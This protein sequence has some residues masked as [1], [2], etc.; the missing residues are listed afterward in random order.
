[1]FNYPAVPA[2]Y[3]HSTIYPDFDFETY[4]E[5]G[6]IYNHAARKWEGKGLSEVGAAVYSEHPTAVARCMTYNLKEGKGRQA[7]IPGM[8][9]P[10]DLFDHI[11]NGGLIEAHNSMFEFLIWTNVC[12]SKYG[13][14]P[15]SLDQL[16]C[17]MSKCRAWSIPAS[18]AKAAKYTGVVDKIADG[19]RLIRKFCI[20]RKPT[21]TDDRLQLTLLDSPADGDKLIEY[22]LG[23]IE[24]ESALSAKVP[25]LQPQEL[26]MWKLDQKI[27]YRGV[28][29]DEEA[30][31][32]CVAVT[33]EYFER[34]TA[35]LVEITGGEVN[36]VAEVAKLREYVNARIVG[37]PIPDVQASTIKE[38][39]SREGLSS[40]V[41]RVLE[42]RKS[43]AS[44]SVKKVYAMNRMKSKDGRL[45]NLF[46]YQGADRTGRFAGSGP[47]PQN[48]PNSGPDVVSCSYCR[49]TAAFAT[50]VGKNSIGETCG[51]GGVYQKEEWGFEASEAF[52]NTLLHEPYQN[53]VYGWGE[54]IKLVTGSLRGLFVA[55]EGHDL[56]CSD[57]SAIEAVVLAALAGE[58]WR[59]EVFRTHGKIY[60]MSA[61]KITGV[62]FEEFERYKAETG[63]HHPMRKKVGKVA[64][65]ASG[66]QGG[67]GAWKNFGADKHMAQP[68]DTS[69]M[70]DQRINEAKNKW[71][72]ESPNIVAFWKALE[73]AAIA[74]V[75]NP[76]HNYQVRGLYFGMKGDVLYIRL[77]SGRMLCY[78]RP[79]VIES[80]LPWGAP[81]LKLTFW[82]WNS[83]SQKGP[84]G[85]LLMDTYGGKLTENIVQ[86]TA[87]DIL[88]HALVKMDPKGYSVVMHIHDEVVCEVPEGF[89]TVEEL[90]DIMA[91]LPE[92]CRDWPVKAA[93][94]WRGKRY[95]K[96]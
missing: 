18:L 6:Y 91:D 57:Y 39:L 77:L 28:K 33:D 36:T 85:W 17:S 62:P 88:T 47:Q 10:L 76:G 69:A 22:C 23:D 96:D 26:E 32:A 55:A 50:E 49:Q 43:L 61:S 25:D 78:H 73:N 11:R 44:A 48:L 59:L 89:G 45:R 86:A 5:A 92:W 58:E 83:N 20:P 35:E 60:E 42:I 54:D 24:T 51:C 12:I 14:P 80:T 68:G 74:A 27:N 9:P 15:L 19:K 93:G 95:R 94:G 21:K 8:E 7:W 75:Q 79:R 2:G 56:L 1:M 30:L 16:R 64:E 72:A 38:A 82:G 63:N 34:L 40:E 66:Y 71:R 90:E 37:N 52:I 67:V 3:S 4:S 84:V 13:F 81:C 31:A 41:R 46:V 29:V 53:R 70:V 65:L 87:R